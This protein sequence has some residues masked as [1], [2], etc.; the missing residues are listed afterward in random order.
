MAR[1]QARVAP[2]APKL[3]AKSE[4]VMRVLLSGEPIGF[5]PRHVHQREHVPNNEI[6]ERPKQAASL[7]DETDLPRRTLRKS[8]GRACEPYEPGQFQLKRLPVCEPCLRSLP[9]AGVRRPNG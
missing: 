2:R 3:E 5:P 9:A 7:D 6:D 8:R 4:H 1:S